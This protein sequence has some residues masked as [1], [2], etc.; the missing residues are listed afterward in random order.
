MALI[1]SSQLRSQFR[2]WCLHVIFTAL[3]SFCFALMAFNKPTAVLAMLAGV[4]TFVVGY[5]LLTSTTI[6]QRMSGT[7]LLGQAVK[8]G[9]KIRM[10]LSLITAPMFASVFVGGFVLVMICP[11][12]WAGLA[13]VMTVGWVAEELFGV[14]GGWETW[15]GSF[16]FTYLTVIVE[17]LIMSFTLV[18]FAFFSLLFMNK[19][20]NRAVVPGPR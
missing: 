18:L 20:A 17:G 8:R 19:K 5:T 10:W 14:T 12:Y 13:A 1:D 9:A 6:Y 3:P 15:S 4:A 11:D 16:V 7:S 2:F